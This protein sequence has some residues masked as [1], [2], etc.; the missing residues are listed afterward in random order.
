MPPSGLP[1]RASARGAELRHLLLFARF[2]ASDE[3]VDDLPDRLRQGVQGAKRRSRPRERH[4][5]ALERHLDRMS[6]A[7]VSYAPR[8]KRKKK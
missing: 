5:D 3:D 1:A 8:R 7:R 4:V 6:Q 2:A